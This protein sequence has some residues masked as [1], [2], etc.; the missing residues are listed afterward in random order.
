MPAAP[1]CVKSFSRSTVSFVYQE[2]STAQKISSQLDTTVGTIG[3]NMGQYPLEMLSTPCGVH[4]MGIEAVLRA[5][6]Y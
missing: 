3:V 2:W 6:Q 1:V 4:A 5:T